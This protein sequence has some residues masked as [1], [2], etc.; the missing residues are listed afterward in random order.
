MPGISRSGGGMVLSS[1]MNAVLSVD[2]LPGRR[3]NM[4]DHPVLGV[5]VMDK[6]CFRRSIP[7]F[8]WFLVVSGELSA[9]DLSCHRQMAR[10]DPHALRLHLQRH[11]LRPAPGASYDGMLSPVV[12][13]MSWLPKHERSA[14]PFRLASGKKNCPSQ[15]SG[16]RIK[17]RLT[18]NL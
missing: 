2:E 13:W 9:F 4:Q 18:H 12:C 8:L 7:A 3:L 5:T 14:G 1:V 6:P 17:A 11:P 15:K 10:A 16:H